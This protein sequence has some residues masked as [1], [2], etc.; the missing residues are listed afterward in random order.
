MRCP[1][2][3][4]PWPIWGTLCSLLSLPLGSRDRKDAETTGGR[5]GVSASN[6]PAGPL[7]EG[8]Q[9]VNP[10]PVRILLSCLSRGGAGTPQPL[11]Y[12]QAPRPPPQ[13][14]HLGPRPAF[15]KGSPSGSPLDNFPSTHF[16]APQHLGYKSPA[17][18]L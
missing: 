15:S 12:A 2:E 10:G 16:P 5:G 11:I 14:W 3:L 4:I 8:L 17:P 6:H 9:P 13:T 1:G 7:G 18:S